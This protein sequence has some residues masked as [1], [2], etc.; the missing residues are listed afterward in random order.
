[1]IRLRFVLVFVFR[2]IGFLSFFSAIWSTP[3][4][5]LKVSHPFLR[6]LF[7]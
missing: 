6:E 5:Y 7:I 1:M 4:K 3:S 2:S